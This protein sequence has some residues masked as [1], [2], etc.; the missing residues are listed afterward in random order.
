[1]KVKLTFLMAA[2]LLSGLMNMF[3]QVN[4]DFTTQQGYVDG[5][6]STQTPTDGVKWTANATHLIV[7]A[8]AG[9][10]S[11]P[12]ASAWQRAGYNKAFASG[13]T[14][15]TLAMKFSFDRSLDEYSGN[16]PI[17]G[18]YLD[19]NAITGSTFFDFTINRSGATNYGLGYFINAPEVI[20][21]ERWRNIGGITPAAL[22]F[23]DA[24]DTSSD[25]LTLELTLTKGIDADSWTAV[26]KVL[27]GSTEVFS[28]NFGGTPFKVGATF[29]NSTSLYGGIGVRNGMAESKISNR[30]VTNFVIGGPLGLVRSPLTLV[31]E[32]DGAGTLTGARLYTEGASVAIK[33]T[34]ADNYEFVKWTLA[35][36][37]TEVSTEANFSYTMPAA[38]TTLKAHF[39][40]ISGL[41]VLG[42]EAAFIHPT[43]VEDVLNVSS[44][45]VKKIEIF[46]LSGKLVKS[47][48]LN[49]SQVDVSE[50]VK[51][52]YV[53]RLIGSTTVMSKFVKK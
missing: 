14:T 3:A 52:V 47:V 44:S 38:A 33:A 9:K 19:N 29:H 21:A 6:L 37:T 50:L 49:G 26:G 12:D 35:D 34:A 1:M 48:Q 45:D 40:T 32:P 53:V 7:D 24:E 36:G 28:W 8:I 41:D 16:H 10:V 18:L 11:I 17:I 39:Q 51:G 42:A 46:N 43:L 22:G 2:F 5:D 25:E 13:T 27:N 4:I 15:F 20:N 31:A 30:T 23:L